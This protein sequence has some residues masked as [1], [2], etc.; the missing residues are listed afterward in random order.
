MKK[1]ASGKKGKLLWLWI[2]IAVV[3]VA[4]IG[5]G[6]YFLFFNGGNKADDGTVKL[7]WNVDREA[8]TDRDTGLSI[9]QPAEDGNFY[10]RFAHNGEQVEIP[11]ADKKLVNFIDSLDLMGLSLDE[12][13]FIVDIFPVKDIASVIGES[14]YVQSVS[15]DTIIANSSI[16]MNGRKVT[17]KLEGDLAIYNVSGKGEFVGEKIEAKD[18]NPMDTIS[19]YGGL[20]PED[21]EEDPVPT[22][23]FVLKKPVESEIYF[24]ADQ[25]YDSS[26]KLTTRVPD[27]NGAY[28]IKWYC[29]GEVVELKCKDQAMVSTIDSADSHWCHWGLEFD[30]DGYII[31][32]IDSFLG[33]R[34]LMQCERF[35]ITEVSEDG[36]YT[37]TSLIKNNGAF[38]QGVVGADCPIYDISSTAK[39]EGQD[40]RKVDSLQLGDRVCIWTDTM[41]NPVQI[42]VT[43]RQAVCDTFWN[44]TRSYSSATGLTTRTPNDRGYYE[45]EMLKAGDTKNTTYYTK[46]VN[47]ATAIDQPSDRVCG[48]KVGEGNI[49]E[50]V[51]DLQA[52]FGNTYFV[53]G[54]YVLDATGSVA[55]YLSPAGS[56]YT[57]NGV[58]AAG[59]KVWNV[60]TLG[61]YGAETTVQYGDTIYAGKTPIG[62]LS[63]AYVTGRLLPGGANKFYWRID[64]RQYDTKAKET[65]REPDADG[66]YSFLFAHNGKQVTLRT[67]NKKFANDLD[68]QSSAP[69]FALETSGDI[70]TQVHAGTYA[71]GGSRYNG[72]TVDAVNG[73]ELEVTSSTGVK[74]TWNI[75]EAKIYNVSNSYTSHKGERIYSI[76]VGDVLANYRDINCTPKVII[77][78]TRETNK[79]AWPVAPQYNSETAETTRVPD[80]NGWYYID[81]AVDGKVRSYKSKNKVVISKADSYTSPFGIQV[82]NGEILF[83]STTTYVKDVKG[84]GVNG[85]TVKSVSGRTVNTI[86]TIGSADK[87]GKSEKLTLASN[88]KIYDVTSEALLAEAAN[89]GSGS[90]GKAVKL[91]KGDVIR[92]YRDNDDNQLYVYVIARQTR[93]YYAYCSHCDQK[94]YWTPYVPSTNVANYDT[95]YYLAGD[96]YMSSQLR[97]YSTARDFEIVLDLNGKVAARDG[98]RCALV[99]YGD[100]LTII[101]SV[102]GGKLGSVN[103][104]AGGGV[105]MVSGS[106]STGVGVVNLYAGTLTVGVSDE[107]NKYSA[108]G[109]IVTNSGGIV[110]MYGGEMIGGVAYGK[111]SD[112]AVGGSIRVSSGTFNMYGGLISGGVAYGGTYQKQKKDA[113]GNPMVDPETGEPIMETLPAA[114]TGGNIYM[115]GS[116]AVVNIYDGVIENGYAARGGNV[117][118]GGGV[119]TMYNGTISGGIVNGDTMGRST[120][121][122]GGNIFNTGTVNILGGTVTGGKIEGDAYNAGGNIMSTGV[123]ANV[124]IGGDAVVT[125]GI[126]DKGANDNI[127]LMYSNLTVSGGTVAVNAEGGYNVYAFGYTAGP[128]TVTVTGGKLDR[129]YLT[130][131]SLAEDGTDT[132]CTLTLGG[133]EVDEIKASACSTINVS[134]K[135]VVN[136]LN[137]GSVLL[138]V[139]AMEDGASITLDSVGVFTKPFENAAAYKDKDYFKSTSDRLTLDVTANNELKFVDPAAVTAPCEHCNGENADWLPWDGTEMAAG[140]HYFLNQN[141]QLTEKITISGEVVLDLK[142]FTVEAISGKQAFQVGS[143]AAMYLYDSSEAKTGTVTGGKAL[144]TSGSTYLSRGGNFIVAGGTLNIYGGNIVGGEADSRGGNIYATGS[145]VINI[146]GGVISGG[147]TKSHANNIYVMYSTLNVYGGEIIDNSGTSVYNVN[148]LGYSGKN[149][150]VNISGG[151]ITGNAN[152]LKVEGEG[153]AEVTVTG[154]LIDG[155][156]A[157]LNV[158]SFKLEGN[159]VIKEL[160]LTSTA[161]TVGELTTGAAIHV[162]STG[163]ISAPFADQAAAE[164]AAAYFTVA[165]GLKLVINDDFALVVEALPAVTVNKYCEHCAQNVDFTE[166]VG[167]SFAGSGHYI[168]TGD[169]TLS[170][171]MAIPAGVEIVLNLDGHTLTSTGPRL[172]DVTGILVIE[173]TSGTNAGTITGGTATRGGNIYVQKAGNFTLYSG[174]ITAGTATGS[175]NDGRGGNIFSAGGSVTLKGGVVSNGVA[176]NEGSKWGGNIFMTGGTLTI[177]DDAVVSGGNAKAGGN[178]YLMY[179][180][181]VMTG[182]EIKDGVVTD[183][184][185]A[186]YANGTSSGGYSDLTFTGGTVSG[187]VYSGQ[188]LNTITV[189]GTPVLNVLNL[190]ST[191]LNV[192]E[193]AAGASIKI[194]ATSG[195][196]TGVLPNANAVVGYFDA[197]QSGYG[198]IVNGE[199]K[200]EVVED[201]STPPETPDP[202]GPGTEPENAQCPHCNTTVEWTAWEGQTT[203]GHYYLTK[204]ETLTAEY[205]L[206]GAV[207][208]VV[209]L[210]GF[211]MTASGAAH[212]F[213]ISDGATVSICD[214]VGGGVISG[215]NNETGRGGNVYVYNGSVFN[216]YG[217]TI[218]GGYAAE[219]GGNLYVTSATANLYGGT[220]T[221]GQVGDNIGGNIYVITGNVETALNISG[222][223][224]VENSLDT[225]AEAVYFRSYSTY[226]G[227]FT[228]TG[229]TVETLVLRHTGTSSEISGTAVVKAITLKDGALLNKLGAF[230]EGASVKFN[231]QE[232]ALSVP[233]ALASADDLAYIGAVDESMI[234]VVNASNELELAAGCEC[235]CGQPASSI[236]WLDA[237]EYLA[238]MALKAT[239]ANVIEESVHLKLSANVNITEIFGGKKQISIGNEYDVNVTIDLNG[240]T[241]TSDYRM[242]NYDGCVLTIM[243]SSEA[244]TG[245][246]TSVG[247]SNAVHGGVFANYGVL[248]ILSGTFTQ[249]AGESKVSRGGVVYQSKGVFNLYGGTLIGGQTVAGESNDGLGG[250]VYIYSGTFNMYGGHITGGNAT[251]TAG[252]GGN[253]YLRGVETV[254]FNMYGGTIDA[255]TAAVSPDVYVGE[256]ATFNQEGGIVGTP[257][258]KCPCGCGADADTVTWLDANTY[259][260]DRAVGYAEMPYETPEEKLAKNAKRRINNED[261]HLKLSADLDLTAVYGAVVQ[262]ELG[263]SEAGKVVIDLNGFT[264]SSGHRFYVYEGSVLTILDSSVAQT[265]TMKSTGQ[266]GM[267][268]GVMINYG[269]VNILGGTLTLSETHAD[270]YGGGVIYSS[271]GIVNM[272]GGTITGG[273]AK[274][275]ATKIATGGNVYI[276]RGEFNFYGGTISNGTVIPYDDGSVTQEAIGSNVC[277]RTGAAF[278]QLGGTVVGGEATIGTCA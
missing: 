36:S 105:I 46:D 233:G 182:G 138:D 87:T 63:Y 276:Y 184:G 190:Q 28:T 177:E 164:A 54:Y 74:G 132:R 70:I 33:S 219:R 10:I 43:R 200:L 254:V 171:T 73:K 79:M 218:T 179:A 227:T 260:A 34:T 37:A 62:E 72:W 155:K 259:F 17:I 220:I 157:A 236:T 5:L 56:G 44:V 154:G 226:T 174:T 277:V 58:L 94:V 76:R 91:K 268:G 228:M 172:F 115:T 48:M 153:L 11:V 203:S 110:N 222:T 4:A 61:K 135:P 32:I 117:H 137:A 148:G 67:K 71:Y 238:T 239:N 247:R 107:P 22:H 136:L 256:G 170:E 2:V 25:F 113:D 18:L 84:S 52:V 225:G 112:G 163:V 243:D 141:I 186:V 35:D 209:D 160:N 253:V 116:S 181:M 108:Q 14:L 264:W 75:S 85:Y 66:Y 123:N 119:F 98:G 216:L 92:T 95:H 122:R 212:V 265:G 103:S 118:V 214:T 20:V 86:Y 208:V 15:G 193:L 88:A 101:D 83:I 167:T 197:V 16:M 53:R 217:G 81:L 142:G 240:F 64:D 27:E 13:G 1:E 262:I 161:L 144:D 245:I 266:A 12:N 57:R 130:G 60:S 69:A 23:I 195:V 275:T 252:T 146:Y 178:I 30:E 6:A 166:W 21:S 102:G 145:G 192:G 31:D 241:W 267:P 257:T 111:T 96:T 271:K 194:N 207:D 263:N 109:G 65:T 159:P 156:M 234:V 168:L 78:K 125:G 196:F 99:R 24:R 273:V 162:S 59:A 210:R 51:Y 42:Y 97:V 139:G 244:K 235:G 29:N 121:G 143:G 114:G 147:K 89:P 128:S 140:G 221:G 82:S 201:S 278:N 124:N 45:I 175:G 158:P 106:S 251:G 120:D 9:R 133:G 248:N 199:G 232:G 187:S 129:V 68:Y 26:K 150:Y 215:A 269:T 205:E 126:G 104:T 7:Y 229:G 93:D 242:Y 176:N 188:E 149:V 80:E 223:A 131:G 274:A 90:F 134:G 272:Y 237:N 49:I 255:G 231:T 183:A 38:V 152:A 40:N 39:S 250:N 41:G 224:V 19:I 246:M 165:A 258:E 198:V 180:T 270:F 77:V 204:D 173:D 50:C 47:L 189:S 3:L 213:Y 191:L 127:Y 211:D 185:A 55:T 8:N 249:P 261:I 100:T 230:Q 206:T 202:E 151:S 169:V